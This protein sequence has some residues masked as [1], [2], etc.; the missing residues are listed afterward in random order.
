MTHPITLISCLALTPAR[1]YLRES[2]KLHVRAWLHRRQTRHW[3]SVLNA[4]PALVDLVRHCPRLILKIYRPYLSDTMNCQQRVALLQA[5]YSFVARHG[6]VPVVAQAARGGVTV[7]SF[8]GKSG[9]G[10]QLRLRTIDVMER[11]GELVLQLCRG[12]ELVAS[13]AFS[14]FDGASGPALG[15]G[16]LQGPRGEHG[17]DLL[18]DTTR[19]LH[20]MRPKAL[21]VRL[22]RQIGYDYGCRDLMLVGNCNRTVRSATR[23]GKVHAD[24][25]ALW[26]ELGAAL[27]A[28]GDYLLP[29]VDLAPPDLTQVV[30]KKRSEARKRHEAMEHIVATLRDGLR[31]PRRP[32]PAPAQAP[33]FPMP[34]ANA[35][36]E[37]PIYAAVA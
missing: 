32:E 10:Y 19:D 5:H 30:S 3:L 22:V 14:F 35:A 6:L 27:G 8:D 28:N 36:L 16:C 18:R 34:A 1:A 9:T 29:C 12:D 17:L 7:A 20:G 11:E 4:E 26:L 23:Q 21:L 2:M 37:T 25:D 13:V 33:Y 24:Y 15:I 31:Q